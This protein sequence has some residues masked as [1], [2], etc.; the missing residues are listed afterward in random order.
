[1][2]PIEKLPV[3]ISGLTPEM[4]EELEERIVE[5]ERDHEPTARVGG[6]GY[7]Q[8]IRKGDILFAGVVNIVIVVYMI[9]AVLIM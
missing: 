6:E 8:K 2:L 1:M 3:D 9:V 4:K 7:V 5:F